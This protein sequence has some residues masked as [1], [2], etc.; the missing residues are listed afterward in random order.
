MEPWGPERADMNAALIASTMANCHRDS[1]RHPEP[2][3]VNEFKLEFGIREKEE[4]KYME[5]GAIVAAFDRLI[6]E[7]RRKG[8]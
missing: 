6:A 1:K 3:T 2:F 4:V 5:P 8:A 7:Q